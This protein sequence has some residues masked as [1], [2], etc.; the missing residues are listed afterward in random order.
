MKSSTLFMII[1]SL[2]LIGAI[3]TYKKSNETQLMTLLLISII[4]L[5]Q[6]THLMDY[7]EVKEKK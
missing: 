2:S 7:H 4:C 5:V 1:G 3:I 6:A